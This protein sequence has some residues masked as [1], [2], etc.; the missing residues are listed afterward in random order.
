[1]IFKWKPCDSNKDNKVSELQA[2]FVQNKSVNP[3][4]IPLQ[5]APQEPSDPNIDKT[6]LGHAW[7]QQFQ[8]ILKTSQEYYN[9]QLQQPASVLLGLCKDRGL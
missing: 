4:D 3:L 9:N 5:P 7:R 8:M 1:M 2:S 6:E